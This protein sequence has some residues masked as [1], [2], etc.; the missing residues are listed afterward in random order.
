[1]KNILIPIDF[2]D[3]SETL[4]ME[5][6][7]F[8]DEMPV[9]VKL[10][11][12]V[13]PYYDAVGFYPEVQPMWPMPI[14]QTKENVLIER[15]KRLAALAAKFAGRLPQPECLVHVG[16][17]AEE[18]IR[19]ANESSTDMLIIGSHGHGALY[20]LLLGD[21]SQVVMRKVNCP[22]LIVRS[23]K[24]TSAVMPGS[25]CGLDHAIGA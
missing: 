25:E 13:E 9:S 20:H 5:A 11:H 2:S 21:V 6:C 22:V 24:H 4:V 19:V 10:L 17:P 15:Q 8:A 1:M 18:I 23:H 7:S 14:L 3:V 12:V 16:L